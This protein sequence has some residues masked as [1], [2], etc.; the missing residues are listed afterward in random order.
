MF[1][2]GTL[3]EAIRAQAAEAEAVGA[4]LA[5]MHFG[6]FAHQILFSIMAP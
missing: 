5:L 6:C 4:G 2:H 1:G 3:S